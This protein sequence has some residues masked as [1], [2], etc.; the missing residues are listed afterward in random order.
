MKTKLTS[1]LLASSTALAL[2]AAPA[3]AQSDSETAAAGV[4]GSIAGAVTG[5]L[6]FG[7]IGAI[8]GGFTGAVIGTEVVDDDAVEYARLNPSD[9]IEVEGN[10]EVGYVVPDDIELR[11][12]EGDPD[13][14]YFYTNDRVYFV[15][16][17]SRT[18]VYSPGTVVAEV[19]AN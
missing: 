16:L 11:I 8:I 9:P 7:P 19:K 1:I 18:V 14:G 12:V 13:H 10:V 3:L 17:E 5:G 4:T 2:I 6:I 15:D